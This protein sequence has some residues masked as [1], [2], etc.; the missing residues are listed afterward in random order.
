M[1]L[2]SLHPSLLD[3]V[4]LANLWLDCLKAQNLL[5]EIPF[6]TDIPALLRFSCYSNSC[7][8][9][10]WYIEGVWNEAKRR[11]LLFCYN[12]DYIH[13]KVNEKNINTKK[14]TEIKPPKSMLVP[15]TDGQ[16]WFEYRKLLN[17]LEHRDEIMYNILLSFDDMN[18]LPSLHPLFNDIQG[19]VEIWDTDWYENQ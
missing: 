10:S 6:R 9:L 5:E 11:N 7:E 16:L 12:R 8:V 17:E 15:V 18:G 3:T 19:E 13:L 1:R 2:W 4:G 14:G